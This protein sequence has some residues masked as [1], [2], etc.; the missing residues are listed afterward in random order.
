MIQYPNR[1]TPRADLGMALYEFAV[2]ARQK[3]IADKVLPSYPGAEESANI[4]V[5]TRETLG[6][7]EDVQ[8]KD[9][10]SYNRGGFD[11]EDKQYTCLEYGHEEPLTEAQK[12]RYT[13]DFNAELA[14]A[15]I[16]FLRLLREYEIR[17]AE[18]L[19]NTTTWATGTAD[20]Y[21]NNS[22]NPWDTA[23]TD[24]V[25]QIE[26]AQQILEK[27]TGFRADTLIIS[28][29]HRKSIRLNT[30]FQNSMK[31]VQRLDDASMMNAFADYLGV[32]RVLMGSMTYNTADEGQDFSGSYVWSDDYAMLAITGEAGLELEE[33]PHL[34]RT[35]V[36]EEEAS[37]IIEVDTY[38]EPQTRSDIYR[39]R[40]FQ[41]EFIFDP[42][43]AHLMKID[44]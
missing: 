35:L 43:F 40:Q 31:Y 20:L 21:T 24:I 30:A 15:R 42:Y 3:M 32:E 22:G 2:N 41:D 17:T 37:D 44:A 9:G 5:I 16:A 12:K 13:N 25:T 1:N 29:A 10:A 36:W 8:H 18:T 38:Y 19:F 34:G 11:V 33:S 39:V 28:S 7:R 6:R 14:R 4:S 27:N 26:T 23:G